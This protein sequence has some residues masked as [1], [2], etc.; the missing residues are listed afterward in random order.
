[1]DLT[2]NVSCISES[3]IEIKIKL[4][5]Y[6]HFFI[7]LPAL[8]GRVLLNRVC[9]SFHPSV[10]LGVFL[11]LSHLFFLNFGMM[12]E[13]RMKL[14]VTKK[15]GKWTKNGPKTWFFLNILKNFVIIFTEFVL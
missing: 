14:C 4:I 2:L 5:F 7:G 6:F 8:A 11:E 12:L 1:M 10:C 9:P 13:T 3:C 15:L